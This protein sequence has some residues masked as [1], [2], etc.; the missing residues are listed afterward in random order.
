MVIP[1][2][3]HYRL[4]KKL[5][6][7]GMGVV[8]EAEDT[9][10]HRPVALKFLPDEVTADPQSLARFQRE[11]RIASALN[12]PNI[13]TIYDMDLQDRH[14]F[15]AME[16]LDGVTL[17]ELTTG[18]PL[19][20]KLILSLAI[21]I[22]DAL[23]AAH[24]RGIIHRDIKPA[25]VFVTERGH[26]KVVDFGLAKVTLNPVD[27]AIST[28]TV[29]SEEHVTGSG[30]ALETVA[31]VSPEQVKGIELDAR[32][33]LFSFGAV[34]YQMATGTLPFKGDTSEALLDSIL[35]KPV[36][37]AAQL[38]SEIP[39]ELEQIISHAL[40]KNKES[41]YQSA[42]EMRVDLKRLKQHLD[43]GS[44]LTKT[45]G[46]RREERHINA[47]IED[48][49]PPLEKGH[50]YRFG[51]NVG[52]LC[53]D[54]IAAP[55]LQGFDWKDNYELTVWVVLSGLGFSVEPRQQLFTLPKTGDTDPIF[56]AI[57]P[58]GRDSLLLRISLYFA[59]EL[60]LLQEFEISMS[61]KEPVQAA[62]T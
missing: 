8:Y 47:R 38:N 15:I 11:A 44:P 59:R 39:V 23:D 18:R 26:A 10:V 62:R 28:P 55:K 29:E 22:A 24:A 50:T 20:P 25:N 56:F 58:T 34:L 7:G 16:F 60:T 27:V 12:H 61:V 19:V 31:Y 41:R 45:T 51:I 43:S 52:K 2:I 30:S 33:D 40:R 3:S 36:P 32:S 5:G 4:I 9:R 42:A 6:R 35:H 49:K 54:T 37:A 17:K 57:T 53:E 1:T 21:E 46:F 48:G 13:C 14:A